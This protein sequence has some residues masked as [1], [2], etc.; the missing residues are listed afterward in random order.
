MKKSLTL[1]QAITGYMLAAQARRLSSHTLADYSN[2]Y[3]KLIRHLAGDPPIADITPTI[4]RQFILDQP[5]SKKTA[6]NYHSGLSALWTWLVSERL[7]DFNPLD[8]VA[9]P[10]PEKRA[11][12]P[13]TEDDIRALLAAIPSS[14]AYTRPGKRECSHARPTADRDR[15][16]L[17]LLLDTG[18]RA[19]ELCDLQIH[20]CDLK[21]RRIVAY[22]KGSKERVLPISARTA[23]AVWKYLATRPQDLVDRPLI[24]TGAG[25]PFDRFALLNL[26]KRIG[27]RAN[28]P[29]TNPHRF[30][31]TFAIMYLRNGG[32]PFTLQMLLGHSDMDTVRRYLAIAQADVEKNHRL[33]SPVDR[34]RL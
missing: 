15:A 10:K 8:Q 5:V 21:N 34:L 24:T 13:F 20:Q 25:D 26:L 32:D 30:R 12:N 9:R 7:A 16:I 17:L 31:H 22:G 23:Q 33:A 19:S 18:M 1:S 29:E 3:R 27:S 11:V 4:L 2:T 28:V 6:L 14:R